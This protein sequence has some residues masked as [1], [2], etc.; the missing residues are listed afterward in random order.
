M[1]KF[2]SVVPQLTNQKKTR[3]QKEDEEISSHYHRVLKSN[4]VKKIVIDYSK[5]NTNDGNEA[6]VQ[7]RHISPNFGNQKVGFEYT[8]KSTLKKIDRRSTVVTQ[9]L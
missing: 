9:D 2:G 4:Y 8:S 3:R 6:S 7:L 1:L 5:G